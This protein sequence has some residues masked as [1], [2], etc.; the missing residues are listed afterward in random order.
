[1][2]DILPHTLLTYYEPLDQLKRSKS[3]CLTAV[4]YSHGQNFQLYEV[5]CTV[6]LYGVRSIRRKTRCIDVAVHR[7]STPSCHVGTQRT[8]A[9]VLYSTVQCT[10]RSKQNNSI[11]LNV[12][13]A[14]MPLCTG[15][16]STGLSQYGNRKHRSRES[17]LTSW[18][19][20]S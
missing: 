7:Y 8:D 10:S 19:P 15:F 3:R 4:S 6:C 11:Q 2:P 14:F 20:W 13:Y 9:F 17:V 5:R 18:I 16:R 12:L 1:M